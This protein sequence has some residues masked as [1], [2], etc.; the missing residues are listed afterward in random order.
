MS[1]KR[2]QEVK[3]KESIHTADMQKSQQKKKDSLSN[4]SL[5]DSETSKQKKPETEKLP[6]DSEAKSKATHL[7]EDNIQSLFKLLEKKILDSM[8]EMIDSK[9]KAK[10]P[11][12][13]K[14]KKSHSDM[15]SS[16]DVSNE[17]ESK[18]V[19]EYMVSEIDAIIEDRFARK[20]RKR[21]NPYVQ[22][23]LKKFQGVAEKL[24]E[25]SNADTTKLREFT[26]LKRDGSLHFWLETIR[27]EFTC[28]K[29]R[30][31]KAY[32]IVPRLI[33]DR[34]L[35]RWAEQMIGEKALAW[36]DI[37][38]TLAM[39]VNDFAETSRSLRAL[40]QMKWHLDETPANFIKKFFE[41]YG[42]TQLDQ[43]NS[44]LML[45]Y[46][47]RAMSYH[48]R[49]EM[50]FVNKIFAHLEEGWDSSSIMREF[51]G[52]MTTVSTVDSMQHQKKK[53]FKCGSHNHIQINCRK[54]IQTSNHIATMQNGHNSKDASQKGFCGNCFRRTG[55]KFGGHTDAE[56]RSARVQPKSVMN[57]KTLNKTTKLYTLRDY[58]QAETLLHGKHWLFQK[59]EY[60]LI[61]IPLTI[62]GIE[63]FAIVDSG[64]TRSVIP[65]I[66]ADKLKLEPT[67]MKYHI[68]VLQGSTVCNE[69]MVPEIRTNRK[70][71]ATTLLVGECE[72]IIV[73]LDLMHLFGISLCGLP[74]VH[75]DDDDCEEELWPERMLHGVVEIS[76]NEQQ[77][78]KEGIQ[79]EL[80][81][82]LSIPHTSVTSHPHGV[83]SFEVEKMNSTK[84]R[85]YPIPHK[86]HSA[87][88][89]KIEEWLHKGVI[90]VTMGSKYNF[91]ILAAPKKGPDGSKSQVRVCFDAR[92]LNHHIK[93]DE[94]PLPLIKDIFETT[95]RF[96]YF[97]TIDLA[98]AFH[99]LPV[100][101][102]RKH[103]L[104]F[105]WNNKTYNFCKTPFGIKTVPSFIQR[106]MESILANMKDFCRVFIDDVIVGANS[107]GELIERVNKVL[108][109]LTRA[110]LRIKSEKCKF[111]YHQISILGHIV[112]QNQIRPDPEKLNN[113]WQLPK[114]RTGKQ[115]QAFLGTVN[116]L[117]QYMPY[118]GKVAQPLER[119]KCT[120]GILNWRPELEKA[121]ED[122]K[123]LLRFEINLT[124]PDF[125][126]QLIIA[127]DASDTGIGAVLYQVEGSKKNIIAIVSKS[128]SPTQA[129][130]P[131]TKKELYAVVFALCKFNN[132]IYGRK[133]L[134][135]TDHQSLLSIFK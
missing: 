38:E 39:K 98:E 41:T 4:E 97:S 36:P 33:E 129:R 61:Q 76:Q 22:E 86:F 68:S 90:E 118:F 124:L 21:V 10:E 47:M 64:A 14:M 120:K 110:N 80:N 11:P 123:N 108:K 96:N 109:E 13:K 71:I 125:S 106:L 74:L 5:E 65:K 84:I 23:S 12:A 43:R 34:D 116:Y 57:E 9:I 28:A 3:R 37:V 93:N 40:E 45:E 111:G 105:S 102:K 16:E 48:H 78:L 99:Q 62:M 53:C 85:Q 122:L 107:V 27:F 60:N 82:N 42:K 94:Y 81:K 128:L 112:G 103:Y 113:I 30:N 8:E 132:Y 114:P 2:T 18:T 95:G 100:N 55:K 58:L 104:S 29:V 49:N 83:F 117:R 26:K 6:K 134:L 67:G 101:P 115:L 24:P 63:C 119:M 31:E 25:V 91:P 66:L 130:Y 19:Q 35:A 52:L 79:Y 32:L 54:G 20:T 127:T 7:S 73:G 72:D 87:I 70:M 88:D 126:K 121:F 89:N 44:N 77:M 50:L 135:E 59:E 69:V 51:I 56:C 17:S 133:F 75:S 15:I 92:Y 131:I 46:L 1:G